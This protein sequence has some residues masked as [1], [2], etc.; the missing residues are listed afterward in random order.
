MS[1]VV[2]G[3]F[4][5]VWMMSKFAPFSGYVIAPANVAMMVIWFFICLTGAVG[6]IAN[7]VHGVGLA[8]GLAAGYG[9]SQ[10]GR[11]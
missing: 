11:S 5:Y 3:L 2:F 6:H 10:L 7:W 8:V 9:Y 1:G 4:G